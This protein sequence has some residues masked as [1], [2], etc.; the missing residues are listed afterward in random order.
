MGWMGW[1]TAAF[2][3]VVAGFA[4]NIMIKKASTDQSYITEV[5][6]FWASAVIAACALTYGSS[7]AIT[8][9]VTRESLSGF[10]PS[11]YFSL[12][13][14]STLGYGDWQPKAGSSVSYLAAAEATTGAFLMALFVVAVAKRWGRG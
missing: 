11:L 6:V 7:S 12:V 1:K 10:G 13:T 9:S 4:A 5:S 3:A 2:I 8:H 14:F